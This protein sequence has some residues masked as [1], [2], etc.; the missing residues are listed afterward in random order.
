MTA[1]SGRGTGSGTSQIVNGRWNSRNTAAFIDVSFFQRP[2]EL[3]TGSMTS[4]GGSQSQQG[5]W[6]RFLQVI[7]VSGE[8]LTSTP[9]EYTT[10]LG[11]IQGGISIPIA[12][13]SVSVVPQ[14]E[15]ARISYGA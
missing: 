4:R 3:S 1:E 14:D 5:S 8:T 15:T 13:V 10:W 6:G 7:L 12:A 2:A 9:S 11:C